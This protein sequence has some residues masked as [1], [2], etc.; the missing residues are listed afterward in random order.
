VL[1]AAAFAYLG[2]AAAPAAASQAY[3]PVRCEAASPYQGP[4]L[5]APYDANSLAVSGSLAGRFDAAMS[6][7]LEAALAKALQATNPAAITVAV[8]RPGIGTWATA[9]TAAGSPPPP[10]FWWA[11]VG[12]MLTAATIL[13]MAEEK[14]LSL[15]DPIEKFVPDVPHGKLITLRHLMAHTSGL[16]SANEDRVVRSKP[17]RM[18]LKDELAIARRHGA[19]FCPGARW[20]YSNTGY[21]LLG[22]VIER[23]DGRPYAE[24]LEARLL[25]RLGAPTL[26]LLR[27]GVPLID[28][29]QPAPPPGS[30]A[31]VRPEWVGAAGSLVGRAEDMNRLLQAILG[32]ELLGKASTA[33]QLRTLYP[34]FDNGAFYGLGLMIYEPPGT[35][36]SWIGHGGGSPGV[37][38]LTIWSPAH[39]AFV[40][41]ALTGEGSP[42]ATAN[43]LLQAL[44]TP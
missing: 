19:M 36:I 35:G 22:A 37:K 17:R 21:S 29:A 8:S 11:S 1:T 20:R 7:R 12:K 6:A 18:T 5:R 10:L 40:S 3:R 30:E 42:E 2:L 13:Q 26:G 14:R 39:R 31:V 34:M 33:E 28:L 44:G 24:A 25:A 41:V 4:V 38:A 43:L 16:F 27:P 9:R 23:V 32:S 15:D